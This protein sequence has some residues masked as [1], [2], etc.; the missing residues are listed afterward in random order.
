MIMSVLK[1]LKIDVNYKNVYYHVEIIW[2]NRICT[3]YLTNL[4]DE[5]LD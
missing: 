4:L 3:K 2:F 5:K 1:R